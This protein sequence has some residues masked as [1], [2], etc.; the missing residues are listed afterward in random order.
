MGVARF[1]TGDRIGDYRIEMVFQG[2]H[3]D[4]CAGAHV[5][6]PRVVTIR[7]ATPE[8][9]VRLMREAC[10]VEALGHAGMPRLYECGRLPDKRPWIATER[11]AGRTL[12]DAI[13]DGAMTPGRVASFVR[14]VAAILDH[15]H[16]RGVVH[17]AVGTDT[18][19][20]TDGARGWPVC[21]CR[22]SEARTLDAA[23]EPPRFGN[24]DA[25][26]LACDGPH[27]AATDV[28]ALG[29]VAFEAL[30]GE[31]PFDDGPLAA[32]IADLVIEYL[33]RRAPATA[34]TEQLARLVDAML[35]GDPTARPSAAEV[36]RAAAQ[37]AAEVERDL[38]DGAALA[39]AM[40][41]VEEIS[42]T[43]PD[44]DGALGALAGMD[45]DDPELH[46]ELEIEALPERDP[47]DPDTD[48]EDGVPVA[49]LSLEVSRRVTQ[50]YAAVPPRT[51]PGTALARLRKPRW[52]PP[53]AQ[54]S[55]AETAQVAGEIS[56]APERTRMKKIDG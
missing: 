8:T 55:S 52:T 12:V 45:A 31:R 35:C 38:S 9:A 19:L 4:I 56:T 30:T 46:V 23:P 18:I 21:L 40:L 50:R 22:W 34:T 3:G 33:A 39:V 1:A 5:V 27:L 20:V 16:R 32:P 26:E 28:F 25:P 2:E 47:R 29:V 6:L 10:I 49:E 44:L 14:D 36:R 17:R 7:V 43:A 51:S 53:Y 54:I 48:Q 42:L 13:T 37:I 11:V 24:N 15:A 41:A